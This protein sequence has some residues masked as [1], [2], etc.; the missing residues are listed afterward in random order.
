MKKNN[1]I[2]KDFYITK[3]F[4]SKPRSQCHHNFLKKLSEKSEK[5]FPNNYPKIRLNL[6]FKR[7]FYLKTK[8][9]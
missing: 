9:M 8:K 7:S 3:G 2:F 4:C 6:Y 5:S 1:G